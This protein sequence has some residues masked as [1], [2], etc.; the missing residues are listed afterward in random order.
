M[1]RCNR[2]GD[3]EDECMCLQ[4][5]LLFGS[6]RDCTS[7]ESDCEF[8]HEKPDD[9]QLTEP[10]FSLSKLAIVHLTYN[11]HHDVAHLNS[12]LHGNTRLFL[13]FFEVLA[14]P[15]SCATLSKQNVLGPGLAGKPFV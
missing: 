10:E 13:S 15:Q 5:F 11:E 6:L 9:D 3:F 2:P 12:P 14:A 8:Y 4:E 1:L 7:S